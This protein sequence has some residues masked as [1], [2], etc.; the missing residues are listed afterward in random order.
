MPKELTHWILADRACAGLSSDSRLGRIIG[1]HHSAYLGGSV[2]P[3]TL[4]H[5]FRGPHAATALALAQSF[6]DTAGNSFVPLIQA[7]LRFPG[8][9]PPALLACMLGVVTHIEADII[10]HPFVYALAGTADAGRHYQV[11]T[12]IDLHFLCNGIQ[13]ATRRLADLISP[14]TQDIFVK[15]CA[16][17]FDPE[18][19]LP[20]TALEQA[21]ALHCRCQEKYDRT[22]W[23]LAV[24][25]LA[26]VRGSPFREQ[27]HLFYPLAPSSAACRIE[28]CVPGWRHPVTGELQRST[29]A[30]L[31]HDAVERIIERFARIEAEGSL[32]AALQTIRG[33]NLLT[34][35]HGVNR[36]AMS[37]VQAAVD[38]GR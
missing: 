14:D 34:G 32:A 20:H 18:G 26:I 22:F 27:R 21:L 38:A 11:E 13:P 37:S 7:E 8:S 16:Q 5:L 10:F 4:L 29:V 35:L 15:T 6:H 12:D 3:D 33:E 1:A 23:K 30:E 9:F 25:L 2:L 17:L 36:S 24:R 28:G 19:T 31:A